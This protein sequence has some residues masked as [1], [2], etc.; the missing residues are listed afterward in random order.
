[1]RNEKSYW[2]GSASMDFP[3]VNEEIPITDINIFASITPA[4]TYTI[5][6][7]QDGKI[8]NFRS[9]DREVY[10]EAVTYIKTIKQNQEMDSE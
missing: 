6:W 1:M 4:Y 8:H 2:I 9:D 10:E 5:L 7:V 3:K